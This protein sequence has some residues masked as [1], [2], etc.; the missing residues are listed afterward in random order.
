[1][2]ILRLG[3]HGHGDLELLGQSNQAVD[4]RGRD[5]ALGIIGKNDRLHLGKEALHMRP[6]LVAQMIAEVA[7]DFTVDAHHL[8]VVRDDARLHRRGPLR[9]PNNGLRADGAALN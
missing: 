6:N 9:R 5:H 1:M 3:V 8:L 2:E 4:Q 7:Q